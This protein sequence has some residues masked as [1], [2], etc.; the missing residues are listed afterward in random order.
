MADDVETIADHRLTVRF[1]AED[2]TKLRE[3]AA[4]ESKRTSFKV[5]M[6]DLIRKFVKIGLSQNEA[7]EA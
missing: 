7:G 2:V 3:M 5:D 4:I 1:D 6:S